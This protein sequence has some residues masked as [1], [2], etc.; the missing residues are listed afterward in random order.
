VHTDRIGPMITPVS[1]RRPWVLARQTVTLDLL[2]KGRTV[3][4]AG[5]G[6]PVHGDFGIF[7]E[8]TDNRT[9]AQ[10]GHAHP[11]TDRL[12]AKHGSDA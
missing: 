3:F 7:G 11:W 4:G 8:E 10:P 5:L 6:S 12:V 1:R 2:A 9:R